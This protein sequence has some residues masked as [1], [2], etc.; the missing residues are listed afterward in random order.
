[1]FHQAN[2]VDVKRQTFLAT[3][4]YISVAA[5]DMWASGS[6]SGSAKIT[7]KPSA[8]VSGRLI[9]KVGKRVRRKA[10]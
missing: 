9:A 8:K 7:G 1:M 6:G 10:L 4:D 2:E 5:V 3:S